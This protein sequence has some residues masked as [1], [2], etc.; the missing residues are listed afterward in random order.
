MKFSSHKQLTFFLSLVFIL[1]ISIFQCKP[2]E[3]NDDSALLLLLGAG[4]I[5]TGAGGTTTETKLRVFVTAASF[6]GNLGGVNGADTK[7]AAD[8]NKPSTGTYKAF[9]TGNSGANGVRY[10]CL[11]DVTNCPTNPGAGTKNWVLQASTSYYRVDQ[12]TKVFTTSALGLI[13]TVHTSIQVSAASYWTGFVTTVTDW[14]ATPGAAVCDLSATTAWT[15]NQGTNSGAVGD[16]ASAA[17]AS[18]KALNTQNCGSTKKLLCVE[19]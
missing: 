15:D 14:S 5:T 3:K 8:A 12:S 2:E 1:S 11:N 16:A 10:A 19:Q 18:I 7:C 9:I 6:D 17:L 13:G 4:A